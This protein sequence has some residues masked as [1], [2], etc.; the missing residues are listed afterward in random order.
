MISNLFTFFSG[1][2]CFVVEE[3]LNVPLPK[4]LNSFIPDTLYTGFLCILSLFLTS[5][6]SLLPW[7]LGF[8]GDSYREISYLL[9]KLFVV[10]PFHLEASYRI[11]LSSEM[12]YDFFVI[13][14]W[15]YVTLLVTLRRKTRCNCQF[16][17]KISETKQILNYVMHAKYV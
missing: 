6:H 13:V 11:P 10:K 3:F 14:S 17:K 4:S 15:P 8:L 5:Q 7:F 16:L 1:T 9:W 2:E 12:I